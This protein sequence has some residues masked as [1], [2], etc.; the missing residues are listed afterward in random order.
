[1]NSQDIDDI[2]KSLDDEQENNSN[3]GFNRSKIITF[4]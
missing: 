3:E 1:M 2:L 4:I